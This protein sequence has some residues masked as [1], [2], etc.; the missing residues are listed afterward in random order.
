[1]DEVR[2]LLNKSTS[3]EDIFRIAGKKCNVYTYPEITKFRSIDELFKKGRSE[4]VNNSKSKLPFDC[5]CCIIL[6]MSGPNYGHWT[7]LTKNDYGINFLD[8]YG[9]V[10]DGQLI[11]VDQT[12]PGQNKKHLLKL[13]TRCKH[14]IYYNDLKLQ[15]MSQNIATCGRYCALYLKYDYMN[16]DDFVKLIKN[17][18]EEY[19]LTPDE[20]VC[21]LSL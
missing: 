15:K 1:M 2:K 6:Y 18:S 8:S 4:I 17:K 20:I 10:I 21:V 11:H 7:I 12:I 19:G 3:P 13:L 9:D 14:K 16:V 5:S